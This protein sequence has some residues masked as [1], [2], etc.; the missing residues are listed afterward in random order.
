MKAVPFDSN[1]ANMV[2]ICMD[3]AMVLDLSFDYQYMLINSM[4]ANPI[5]KV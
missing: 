3:C 1:Y 5:S 2:V 4:T